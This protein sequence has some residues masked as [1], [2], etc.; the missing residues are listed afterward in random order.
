MSSSDITRRDFVMGLLA[1]VPVLTSTP[2][3]VFGYG[4]PPSGGVIESLPTF[5]CEPGEY[6]LE[7]SLSFDQNLGTAILIGAPDVSLDLQG[8]SI[9]GIGYKDPLQ[10]TIGIYVAPQAHRA[11][12]ING[13]LNGFTYGA[14]VGSATLVPNN[15][16]LS[17]LV[18]NN[19]LQIGFVNRASDTLIV[20][21][22]AI[23]TGFS[24]TILL[25][26]GIGIGFVSI[27]AAG[28]NGI[29]HIEGC[30]SDFSGS[31]GESY[32]NSPLKIGILA[33][34]TFNPPVVLS[35]VS[36]NLIEFAEIGLCLLPSVLNTPSIE[37]YGNS[38]VG[39]QYPFNGGKNLGSNQSV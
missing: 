19:C 6:F 34:A 16:T 38:V 2:D 29:C 35:K 30:H 1:T 36:N 14:M 11:T 27:W 18:A 4:R 7:R 15:V 3:L 37:Y 22:A 24:Q 39:A 25:C 13:S 8:N 32:P 5:L 31:K 23:D 17:T 33:S 26:P 21:C 12:V 10:K 9:N 20:E 28:G